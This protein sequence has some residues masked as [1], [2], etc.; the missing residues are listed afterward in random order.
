MGA[1][2]AAEEGPARFDT[3]PDDLAPAML[4]FRRERVNS[5]FK[6]IEVT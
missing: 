6:T 2:S 1:M 4:A 5:A 3:M